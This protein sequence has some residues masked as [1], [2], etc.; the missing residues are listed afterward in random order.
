[1]GEAGL[2]TFP[3]GGLPVYGKNP[4]T[5]SLKTYSLLVQKGVSQHFTTL[6]VVG[7]LSQ[8]ISERQLIL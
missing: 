8:K 6:T 5:V 4:V 7:M 3:V 1:M 2:F